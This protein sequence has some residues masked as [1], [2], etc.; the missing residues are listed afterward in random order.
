MPKKPKSDCKCF[1]KIY[2]SRQTCY[3]LHLDIINFVY[4]LEQTHGSFISMSLGIWTLTWLKPLIFLCY[5]ISYFA[6]V[7][8]SMTLIYLDLSTKLCHSFFSQPYQNQVLLI[9][10]HFFIILCRKMLVK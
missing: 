10:L 2:F 6:K 7:K 4:H 1:S 9:H 8:I 5:K 3:F